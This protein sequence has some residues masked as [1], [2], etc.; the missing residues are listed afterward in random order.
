M[1]KKT[2]GRNGAVMWLF[3]VHSTKVDPYIGIKFEA[4]AQL[5]DTVLLN[6]TLEKIFV[7]TLHVISISTRCTSLPIVSINMTLSKY[8][9][10]YH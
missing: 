9:S 8:I 5:V 7:Y 2:T 10:Q 4:F 6:E 1:N 3:Y